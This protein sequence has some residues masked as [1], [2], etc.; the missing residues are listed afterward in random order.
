[1]DVEEKHI[2]VSSRGRG[3]SQIL[4]TLSDHYEGDIINKNGWEGKEHT[5]FLNSGKIVIQHSR[6]GEI[7]RRIFEGMACGKLVITDRLAEEVEL[8]SLFIDG[9]NII[10]YDDIQDCAEK[11]AYYNNNPTERKE[12][13]WNGYQKVLNNH[14]QKQ[15][16]DLII[17]QYKNFKNN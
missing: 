8:E 12:I 13:A 5:E 7:T 3:S 10:L 15:R 17:Q 1:M 2:A 6:W 16:V 11:I 4:D 14:T 9:E